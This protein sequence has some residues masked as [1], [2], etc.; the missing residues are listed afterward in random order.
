MPSI[1]LAPIKIL[2]VSGEVTFGDVLQI[3]PKSTS[4]SNSGA[5]GG[6]TGDFCANFSLIS[7]TNTLDPDLND[8][9]NQ[10]NN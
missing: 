3:T 4:K 2:E 8:S 1:I 5:S 7:L 10:A 6:S 9:S